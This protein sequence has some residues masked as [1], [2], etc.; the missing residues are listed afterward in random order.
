MKKPIVQQIVRITGTE[1]ITEGISLIRFSSKEI[2]SAAA[3]GQFVN[4]RTADRCMPLL[5]RPFS[6]SRI[7]GDQ[8]ELL[9]AVI[10]MGTKILASK[11][12]G[13]ELDV[14]GPLGQSFHMEGD[15]S[16]AIIIA[17]GLG[18][19]PFPFIT[20]KLQE[21]GK[22]ILTLVGARTGN[23]ILTRHL[24]NVLVATDDGSIGF[25]GN[26]VELLDNVRSG[27]SF[28][29]PKLFA[30]GPSKMLQVLADYANKNG[31]EC[32]VSLEGEMACGIGICQGCPVERTDGNKKYSLVCTEGPTFN[33]KD[34]IIR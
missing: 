9:Y 22:Q 13:D 33:S 25:R 4:I 6:I 17:G 7:D 29:R 5:R 10:G 31:L 14:L 24:K 28:Q 8:I 18:A 32:E 15:Y 19:A 27:R 11:S 1:V 20:E 26:V 23:F 2:S 16:E 12:I 3:P 34:I 21:Q 30:C